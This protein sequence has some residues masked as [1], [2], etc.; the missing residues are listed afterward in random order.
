MVGPGF[1]LSTEVNGAVIRFYRSMDERDDRA[2]RF[3]A[4]LPFGRYL[5]RPATFSVGTGPYSKNAGICRLGGSERVLVSRD[6]TD[7]HSSISLIVGIESHDQVTKL[8]DASLL[9]TSP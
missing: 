8:K 2:S 5:R 1:L 7:R 4:H 6:M 3:A 9:C